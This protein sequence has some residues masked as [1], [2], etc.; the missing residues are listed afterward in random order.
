MRQRGSCYKLLEPDYFAYVFVCLGNINLQINLSRQSPSHFATELQ[1]FRFSVKTFSSSA[2]A[3]EGKRRAAKLF[4]TA[5]E[6][7]IDCL[8][9]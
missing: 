5:L 2:L 7:Q 8:L 1:S 3:G 9:F 6:Q 4:S